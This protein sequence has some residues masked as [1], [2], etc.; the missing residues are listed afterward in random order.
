MEQTVILLHEEI[1]T[2][3]WEYQHQGFAV[4]IL[5]IQKLYVYYFMM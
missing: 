1:H 2:F 4:H 5:I 3:Q